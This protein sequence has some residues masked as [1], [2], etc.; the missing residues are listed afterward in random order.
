MGARRQWR[1]IHENFTKLGLTARPQSHL[2]ASMKRL[3]SLLM[4]YVFL[5]AETFALR[6]G[7]SGSGGEKVL[8]AYS[9]VLLETS[10][11]TDL[12][13]FLLNAVSN[14][15]SSGQ[16]VFF[17]SDST[18]TNVF[19]VVGESDI[20]TG[21]VTGISDTSRGGSGR[22]FGLFNGAAATGNGSQRS[23][24]GQLSI[25]ATKAVGAS[26]TQRLTGT[27]SSRTV[28]IDSVGG[29]TATSSGSLKTYSVD[30][31]LTS[32]DTTGA[33][34]NIGGGG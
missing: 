15:A 19:G 6:G 1:S 9:G 11:G 33:G 10:G 7:P 12:G 24:N 4:C 13:L 26:G 25:T 3:L 31:W 16:V 34:F 5:Q 17:S 20:Y 14:G 23:I 2:F 30:G 8:G 21:T 32:S 29:N 28:A 27:G 22:F 18:T